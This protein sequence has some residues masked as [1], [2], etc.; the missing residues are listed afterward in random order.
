MLQVIPWKDAMRRW[1]V[2]VAAVAITFSGSILAVKIVGCMYQGLLSLQSRRSVALP[3][4][5]KGK[6]PQEPASTPLLSIQDPKGSPLQIT[7][8]SFSVRSTGS[9]IV[10]VPFVFRNVSA[11]PIRNYRVNYDVEAIAPEADHPASAA[12][13]FG[14]LSPGQS[15]E[16]PLD[17]R[18][19]AKVTMAV[20]YVAFRDGTV[21]TRNGSTRI[22]PTQVFPSSN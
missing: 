2:Y 9:D 1:A 22:G 13:D 3:T 14:G 4:L 8:D 17:F 16:I 5:M 12:R 11:K 10:R 19:H 6:L 18:H 7:V 20:E 21:W 15:L